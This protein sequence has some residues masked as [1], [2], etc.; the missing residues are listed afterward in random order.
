[1]EANKMDPLLLATLFSK[2]GEKMAPT[3]PFAGIGEELAKGAATNQANQA[4]LNAANKAA[5]T[6]KAKAKLIDLASK[7][8]PKAGTSPDFQR[9]LG[10]A[11]S[12]TPEAVPTDPNAFSPTASAISPIPNAQPGPPAV[13]PI[14]NATPVAPVMQNVGDAFQPQPTP[15]DNSTAMVLGAKGTNDAY[16]FGLANRNSNIAEGQLGVAQGQLGVAQTSAATDRMRVEDTMKRTPSEI[17]LQGAQTRGLNAEAAFN[18]WKNTPD[19]RAA[20]NEQAIKVA[21]EPSR[22]A[23]AADETK[24]R[25]MLSQIDTLPASVRDAKIA[26][27]NYTMGQMARLGI[28]SPHGTAAMASMEDTKVRAETARMNNQAIINQRKDA[29]DASAV[30]VAIKQIATIDTQIANLIKKQSINDFP[31]TEEGKSAKSLAMALGNIRSADT[32]KQITE[33]LKQKKML[34]T[35]VPGWIYTDVP[36]SAEESKEIIVTPEE[37]KKMSEEGKRATSTEHLPAFQSMFAPV[38]DQAIGKAVGNAFTGAVP[39]TEYD[40]M[41]YMGYRGGM[42]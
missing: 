1:M 18:E 3:S 32:D 23:A 10:T 9:S 24:T 7:L 2:V 21:G 6:Y 17:A 33:L 16:Q 34:T 8:D 41:R 31:D 37:L 11:L 20:L 38:S 29:K 42:Q 25:F 19:G 22:A 14:P 12:A 39:A 30:D 26:G 36:T 15:F 27:T 40:L 35:K 13:A 5:E 4:T 28:L